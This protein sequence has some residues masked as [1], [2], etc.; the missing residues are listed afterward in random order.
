MNFRDLGKDEGGDGKVCRE[1]LKNLLNVRN[2]VGYSLASVCRVMK[3]S[4][5]SGE[6]TTIRSEITRHWEYC[7][8]TDE[9]RKKFTHFYKDATE[10]ENIREI[11]QAYLEKVRRRE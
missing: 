4:K 6:I 5:Q 8:Y 9:Q 10:D 7:G 2:D 11:H 3:A 1:R